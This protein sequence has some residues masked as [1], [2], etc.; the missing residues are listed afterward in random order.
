MTDR[1]RPRPPA[2][3]SRWAQATWRALFTLHDFE[4]YEQLML[5]RALE[6]WDRADAWLVESQT[7]TGPEQARLVKQSMDAANTALRHWRLLKFAPPATVPTRPG[8]PAGFNWSAA[9]KVTD[10]RGRPVDA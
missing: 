5:H 1:R 7:A 3:L 6:W 10:L 8:R 9:R 2:G 4:R